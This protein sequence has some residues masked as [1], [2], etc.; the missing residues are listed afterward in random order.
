M[1]G[2]FNSF[3]E[4]SVLSLLHDEQLGS[5]G[6]YCVPEDTE[7][8]IKKMY[9]VTEERYNDMKESGALSPLAGRIYDVYNLY[10]QSS[11]CTSRS[12]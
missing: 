11:D 10:N 9:S 3:P 8:K 1:C 12:Q 2:D 6:A 5:K 7:E 4:S